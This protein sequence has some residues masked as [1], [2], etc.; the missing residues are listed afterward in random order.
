MQKIDAA[1]VGY[2]LGDHRTGTVAEYPER[3]SD[4]MTIGPAN[5]MMK[6]EAGL[7]RNSRLV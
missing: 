3:V 2:S 6:Q 7:S 4:V 5:S 1:I